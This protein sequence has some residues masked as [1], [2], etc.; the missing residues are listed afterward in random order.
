M[1]ELM[2]LVPYA[3]CRFRALGNPEETGVL[4]RR[5]HHERQRAASHCL[6]ASEIVLK[7]TS[8][9]LL[10]GNP[11]TALRTVERVAAFVPGA[12]EHAS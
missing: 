9:Q 8:P 10:A 7:G 11:G 3:V 12:V 2:T 1:R 5:R 6:R 4:I